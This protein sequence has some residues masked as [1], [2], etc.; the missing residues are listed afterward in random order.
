MGVTEHTYG[1]DGVIAVA[2]LAMLTGNVG[3]PGAGVNPL[4]GQNNVQGACDMGCL[5]DVYPGYQRVADPAVQAKFESAWGCALPSA[6]GLTLTQMIDRA[7]H[8]KMKALYLIG[9]NPA[10]SEPNQSHAVA[11]LKRLDLLVV[12]DIFLTET[13]KLAHVVLPAASFAEKNG[14]FT[15][16]ERR[17][18]RVR[19]AVLPPGEARPDWQI[20]C[21]LA[22]KMGVPGFDFND[23]KEVMEEISQLT[24]IYGGISFECLEND[25]RQW[26][27]PSPEHPGTPILHT[28]KFSRGRGK[29]TALTYSPPAEVS[30]ET[31][32]FILTTG[33]SLYQY[34]TGT[35]TRKVSALGKRLGENRL[36]IN[37]ADA[38]CLGVAEGD[39]VKVISRR[40]EMHTRA[41]VTDATPPGLVFLNFHFA[42]APTNILTGS[43]YDNKT[44]TPDYKVT[45]VKVEK[46]T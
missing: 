27:C 29:F 12:Q 39:P 32:P 10:L 25:S 17:V 16:T 13:A 23:P 6:P 42:E 21:A 2:N 43:A 26:P 36:E 33:R 31:Y 34:H 3:S 28:E 8:G 37:P 35:M 14:T 18:Q 44:G 46:I 45:A 7:S 15:N 11:A 4:R 9:E 41:K 19:Q 22:K 38:T 24:P 30:D 20:I 5:P 40:G 1:T